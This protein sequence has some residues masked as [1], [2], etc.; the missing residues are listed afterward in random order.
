M[1]MIATALALVGAF[2]QAT[3]AQMPAPTAPQTDPALNAQ[4]D[5][6]VVKNPA[7]PTL[8]LVGDS[9]VRNGHGDGA[10][11]QWG[12]GEPMVAFFD[13]QRSMLSILQ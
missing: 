11:G 5:L 6:P 13:P 2:R 10:N 8:Y 7:L 3:Y 1:R 4:L 9:T 12:W